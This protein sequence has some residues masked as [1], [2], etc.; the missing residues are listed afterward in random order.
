MSANPVYSHRNGETEE[1]KEQ[2]YYFAKDTWLEERSLRI[3]FCNGIYTFKLWDMKGTGI[4]PK[5]Q[6]NRFSYFGPIPEPRIPGE[7]P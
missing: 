6:E 3:V 5:S 2:G 4:I 7:Q 1:P